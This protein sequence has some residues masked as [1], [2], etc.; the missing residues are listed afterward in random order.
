MS[1]FTHPHI[2]ESPDDFFFHDTQKGLFRADVK[3]TLFHTLK[4]SSHLFSES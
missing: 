2:F 1:A 3:A 4:V